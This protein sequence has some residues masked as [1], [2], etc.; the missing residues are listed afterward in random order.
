MNKQI[1]DM[2][3]NFEK[4]C[5]WMDEKQSEYNPFEVLFQL[6]RN[7][8]MESPPDKIH[9]RFV[10]QDLAEESKL[11]EKEIPQL[12]DIIMPLY[13]SIAKLQDAA[14]P[15]MDTEHF[16]DEIVDCLQSEFQRLILRYKSISDQIQ[17]ILLQESDF[18]L[19][20]AERFLD[21]DFDWETFRIEEEEEKNGMFNPFEYGYEE[22][23]LAILASTRNDYLD[24]DGYHDPEYL[25]SFFVPVFTAAQMMDKLR[26]ERMMDKFGM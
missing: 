7:I 21:L 23:Y 12:M 15:I 18:I 4:L 9:I 13:N 14:I 5:D 25:W 17:A 22:G 11:T 26:R 19:E 6:F 10:I 2:I 8:W 16:E 20:E 1:K 24:E 3:Q